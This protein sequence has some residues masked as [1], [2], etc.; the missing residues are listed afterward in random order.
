MIG[1][2]EFLACS[3]AGQRVSDPSRMI[4]N[5]LKVLTN[6]LYMPPFDLLWNSVSFFMW[7]GAIC[8]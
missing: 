5:D 7:D 2:D 6:F 4:G 3:V 8:P 1:P